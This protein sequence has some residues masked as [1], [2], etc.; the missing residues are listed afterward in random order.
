LQKAH[1]NKSERLV[2]KALLKLGMRPLFLDTE[3][4]LKE[5]EIELSNNSFLT[6]PIPII[7]NLQKSRDDNKFT[8]GII[9]DNRKEKKTGEIAE[10]LN[11]VCI[12]HGM[13]L[14]VGSTDKLLLDTWQNRGAKT[15]N[16]SNSDDYVRAF[17]LSDAIVL[18]Y[19]CAAYYYRS[20]GVICDAIAAN[21]AIICPNYPVLKDQITRLGQV[22]MTFSDTKDIASILLSIKE[23]FVDFN[24]GLLSQQQ[25]RGIQNITT[26]I[27]EYIESNNI[28]V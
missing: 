4:G 22:G 6:L 27:N 16:T 3:V 28:K 2:F 26:L 19:D 9:G 24:A 10:I 14:L 18:N 25:S 5:L 23:N 8:V 13:Q 15:I 21:T 12:E 17:C 20:S 11:K 1:A 7:K